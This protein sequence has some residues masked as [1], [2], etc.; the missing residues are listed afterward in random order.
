MEEYNFSHFGLTCFPIASTERLT[1]SLLTKEKIS[2]VFN[3]SMITKMRKRMEEYNFS[4]FGLKS[5]RHSFNCSKGKELNTPI[6]LPKPQ[7]LSSFIRIQLICFA[8]TTLWYHCTN[9]YLLYSYTLLKKRSNDR[10]VFQ[11]Y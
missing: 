9:Y 10:E 8:V 11:N 6:T 7:S 3:L 1:K 4:H 5:F 2:S